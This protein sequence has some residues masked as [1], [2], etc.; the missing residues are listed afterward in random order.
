MEDFNQYLSLCGNIVR[1]FNI[2]SLANL[3]FCASGS[4]AIQP[5]AEQLRKEFL[6][7]D[8]FQFLL[9]EGKPEQAKRKVHRYLESYLW[10]PTVRK[11]LRELGFLEGGYVFVNPRQRKVILP[12]IDDPLDSVRLPYVGFANERFPLATLSKTRFGQTLAIELKRALSKSY[13]KEF[14]FPTVSD[15]HREELFSL[16]YDWTLRA[17]EA[18]VEGIE[19][20]PHFTELTSLLG[21]RCEECICYLRDSAPDRPNLEGEWQ[22]FVVQRIVEE[23]LYDLTFTQVAIGRGNDIPFRQRAEFLDFLHYKEPVTRI[24]EETGTLFVEDGEI[25]LLLFE[26]HLHSSALI[27]ENDHGVVEPL[28]EASLSRMGLIMKEEEKTFRVSHRARRMA[29]WVQKLTNINTPRLVKE[30]YEPLRTGKA[31]ESLF[32]EWVGREADVRRV[33]DAILNQTQASPIEENVKLFSDLAEAL[34]PMRQVRQ[35]ETIHKLV[36]V[37]LRIHEFLRRHEDDPRDLLSFVVSGQPIADAEAKSTTVFLGTVILEHPLDGDDDSEVGSNWVRLRQQ[38]NAI[39]TPLALI[40]QVNAETALEIEAR[41]EGIMNFFGRTAHGVR[42]RAQGIQFDSAVVQQIIEGH[43]TN[44]GLGPGIINEIR[45][46]LNRI[47]RSALDVAQFAGTIHRSIDRRQPP[48][49]HLRELQPAVVF[50]SMFQQRKNQLINDAEWGAVRDNLYE[51]FGADISL[52]DIVSYEAEGASQMSIA[53]YESVL[54]TVFS[55]SIKNSFLNGA[56]KV[57]LRL[58]QVADGWVRIAILDN[59]TGFPTQDHSGHSSFFQSPTGGL[60][61]IHGCVQRVLKGRNISRGNRANGE[62]GAFIQ[63]ELPTT[64]KEET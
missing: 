30:N 61:V 52:N 16:I 2:L 33:T 24:E 49:E 40:G 58:E 45:E 63:F 53:A 62:M 59:G 20:T 5:E 38:I 57:R 9:W 37:N 47:N 31:W 44:S 36:P 11:S 34:F 7:E 25:A 19:F 18:E 28:T 43:L 50:R 35:L 4:E 29:R 12:H 17:V 55:E 6:F 15:E 64:I 26:S 10:T 13:L 23:A 14:A 27:S 56:C 46:I 42:T 41:E 3:K 54:S 22:S 21:N 39:K 8:A 60:G 51:R 32:S 1:L 48:S